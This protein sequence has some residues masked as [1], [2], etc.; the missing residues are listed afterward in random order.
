MTA[1]SLLAGR[2]EVLGRLGS[3]SSG[4][5]LRVRDRDTDRVVALKLLRPQGVADPA[6]LARAFHREFH[7]LATLRHPHL[8]A[9]HDHGVLDATGGEGAPLQ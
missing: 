8:V 9:V 5:V 3:G 6:Q 1:P 2:F 4:E 7:V